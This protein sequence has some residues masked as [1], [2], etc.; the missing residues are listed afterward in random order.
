MVSHEPD[1]NLI[2]HVWET[3]GC[4]LQAVEPPVQNLGQLEAAFHQEWWQLP[5]QHIR[6]L[7]GGMRRRTE[8]VILAHGGCTGY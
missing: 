5:Q 8:T 7:I 1:L 3:L 2:D 6:Q 4:L